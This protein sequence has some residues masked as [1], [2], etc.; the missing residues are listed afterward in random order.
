M[1][2]KSAAYSLMELLLVLVLVSI[3]LAMVVPTWRQHQLAAG[4]QEAWLTLQRLGLQEQM[5]QLQ[6]G[7]YLG[8]I[9]LLKPA[10]EDR[11]YGYQIQLSEEGFLLSATVNVSGPQRHDKRCWQ[12]TL[13]DTG[14]VKSLS[15]EGEIQVCN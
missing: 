12:L 4:R 3:T 5:W 6:H 14:E 15:K 13:S 9:E 1:V 2:N 11:R 8:D 7:H 10:L